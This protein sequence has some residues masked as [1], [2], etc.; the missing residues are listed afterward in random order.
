MPHGKNRLTESLTGYGEK[1]TEDR[2][3]ILAEA[4]RECVLG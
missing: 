4:L 2:E 3:E 1:G